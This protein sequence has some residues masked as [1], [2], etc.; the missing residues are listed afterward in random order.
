LHFATDVRGNLA[1]ASVVTNERVQVLLLLLLLLLFLLPFVLSLLL[2]NLT[3]A[4]LG[5]G[6]VASSC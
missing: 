1:D 5:E 6:Q 3:C 4:G 2:S